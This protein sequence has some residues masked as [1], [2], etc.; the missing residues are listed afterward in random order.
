MPTD[1]NDLEKYLGE[2]QPRAVRPLETSWPTRMAWMRRL[3]AAALLL[4]SVGGGLWYARH[5]RNVPRAEVKLATVGIEVHVEE[6]RIN[7]IL[8]TKLA[9]DDPKR[10]D[11]QLEAESRHVLPDLQ[12]QQSTLRVLAKE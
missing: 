4:L 1:D 9:L 10:F 11:E 7:P 5:E 3:A 6:R 2:F 12:G 8:L